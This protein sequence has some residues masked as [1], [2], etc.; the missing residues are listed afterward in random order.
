[1]VWS[2]MGYNHTCCT[3]QEYF[4]QSNYE[5]VH[6]DEWIVVWILRN[7]DDE[8]ITYTAR[9]GVQYLAF[10]GISSFIRVWCSSLPLATW[11]RDTLIQHVPLKFILTIFLH[12]CLSFPTCGFSI[13]RLDVVKY[14]Y[15]A[16]CVFY[17]I[18]KSLIMTLLPS[19]NLHTFSP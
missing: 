10:C 1:M 12:L 11:I 13:F 3:L 18:N 8:P 19:E 16:S 4:N 17:K 2:V 5:Q 15:S 6:G 9:R 7:C 14:L